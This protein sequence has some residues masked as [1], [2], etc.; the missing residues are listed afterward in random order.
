M[1]RRELGC[2]RAVLS[3]YYEA[4]TVEAFIRTRFGYCREY[5]G[6]FQQALDRTQLL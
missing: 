3:E 4:G 1:S 5:A 6:E 2:C